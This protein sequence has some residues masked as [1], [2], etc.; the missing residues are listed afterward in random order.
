MCL[1]ALAFLVADDQFVIVDLEMPLLP[2]SCFRHPR[3]LAAL[4]HIYR[5]KN[6]MHHLHIHDLV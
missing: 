6:G 3:P 2:A 5:Q 4:D 1:Q